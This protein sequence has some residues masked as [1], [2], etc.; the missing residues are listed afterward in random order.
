MPSLIFAVMAPAIGE[1]YSLANAL[2]HSMCLFVACAAFFSLALLLS[3]SYSDV[4]R[5]MVIALAAG[6]VLALIECPTAASRST[7]SRIS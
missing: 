6:V 1:H 7:A 2:V 5:P 3:T 4:W